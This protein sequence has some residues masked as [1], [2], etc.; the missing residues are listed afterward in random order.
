MHVIFYIWMDVKFLSMCFIYKYR[1]IYV[2]NYSKKKLIKKRPWIWKQLRR[3]VCEDLEEEKGK[4]KSCDFKLER[5]YY[6]ISIQKEICNLVNESCPN[7]YIVG[8][9]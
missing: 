4:A 9:Q 6:K 5:N 2:G 3:N 8:S 1:C 7:E